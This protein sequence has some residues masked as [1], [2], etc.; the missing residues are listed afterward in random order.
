MRQ[1]VDGVSKLLHQQD[2]HTD[3]DDPDD[4]SEEI[5]EE[6]PQKA[7]KILSNADKSAK[8]VATSLPHV[9]QEPVGEFEMMLNDQTE[10]AQAAEKAS[11]PLENNT[12][13][14]VSTNTNSTSRTYLGKPKTQT[15][16]SLPSSAH[17]SVL[18][19]IA[20][21]NYGASNFR[22]TSAKKTAQMKLKGLSLNMEAPQNSP[23]I[24]PSSKSSHSFQQFV[25]VAQVASSVED[26][27]TDVQSSSV[28]DK[29]QHSVVVNQEDISIIDEAGKV[30][31]LI[32]GKC[33]QIGVLVALYKGKDGREFFESIEGLL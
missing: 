29:E 8:A 5:C 24:S 22:L 11:Q 28:H 10:A 15:H 3:S 2:D 16:A 13:P 14:P 32:V 1:S 4:P 23:I 30:N 20:S 17:L 21:K 19:A 12:K 7:G 6:I 33:R 31:L 27:P 18:K 9:K 25:A 26:A